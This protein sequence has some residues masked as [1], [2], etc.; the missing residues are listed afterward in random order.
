M[1]EIVHL[2]IVEGK[3]EERLVVRTVQKRYCS[4]IHTLL[5]STSRR[6]TCEDCG[7][8]VEAFAVLR[9][10]AQDPER[11][12]RQRDEL[13]REATAARETLAD[14]KREITNAKARLRTAQRRAGG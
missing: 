11:F 7:E 3:G 12:L 5:D 1:A 9:S 10:L 6:V 8:E 4:H 13:R 14:L 2:K